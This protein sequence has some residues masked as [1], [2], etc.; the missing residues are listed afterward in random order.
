ML[1]MLSTQVLNDL[2]LLSV[3]LNFRSNSPI[4]EVHKLRTN[5]C[6]YEHIHILITTQTSFS[7]LVSF[8][9]SGGRN[10]IISTVEV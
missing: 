6:V 1:L 10:F 2:L 3:E 8:I 4:A 7:C 9:C 5:C